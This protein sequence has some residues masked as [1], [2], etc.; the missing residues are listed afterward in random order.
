M[1]IF[2]FSKFSL[3]KQIL[4]ESSKGWNVLFKLYKFILHDIELDNALLSIPKQSRREDSNCA[5]AKEVCDLDAS[6]LINRKNFATYVVSF[7]EN[8]LSIALTCYPLLNKT[9]SDFREISD[10]VP[11]LCFILNNTLQDSFQE[12]TK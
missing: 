5:S 7:P 1:L 2:F 4:C 8:S 3:V 12:V 6:K 10:A 9:R 11:L